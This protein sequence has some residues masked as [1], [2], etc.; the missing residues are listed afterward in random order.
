MSATKTFLNSK[1]GMVTAAVAVGAIALYW[2][3]GRAA[4][5]TGEAAAKVGTAA[6]PLSD[7]NILY[8]ATNAIGSA[9]TFDPDFS[10]GS[11]LYEKTHPSEDPTSKL[12]D[13]ATA[14]P[15]TYS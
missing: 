14:K 9:F 13:D 2:L 12:I 1:A 4:A 8:R 11:W 10:L 15:G 5:A 6:N 3:A 7:Q